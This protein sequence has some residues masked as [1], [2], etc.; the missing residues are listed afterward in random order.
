LP[1]LGDFFN[2][3]LEIVLDVVVFVV[4]FRGSVDLVTETINEI[5]DFLNIRGSSCVSSF[6]LFLIFASEGVAAT[7]IDFNILWNN[8]L[9]L[10]LNDCTFVFFG[11]DELVGVRNNFSILVSKVV[12]D[13]HLQQ[14]IQ[15]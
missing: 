5:V 12:I 13:S 15:L 11:V 10:N 14:S 2:G 1:F 8:H 7:D 6:F 3:F 4:F 9:A